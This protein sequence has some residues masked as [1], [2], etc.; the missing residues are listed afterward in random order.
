MSDLSF[1]SWPL[2]AAALCMTVVA[3]VGFYQAMFVMPEYFS[4]PPE[5]LRRY[6]AD[7]SWKFWL[8]L[9]A[10]T[11]PA[12]VLSLV[13]NWSSDRFALVLSATVCYAAS[14]IATFIWFIPGVIEFN[15]VDVNGPY[16]EEL[17]DKGRRWLRRSSGRLVLML[18]AAVLL[19]LALG[20]R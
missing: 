6:Q 2:A 17:A 1:T 4:S 16:S 13:D 3:G 14:W 11:L 7:T 10:V 5:S 19:V 8:P 12:L 9:H 15:K 20:S 18:A